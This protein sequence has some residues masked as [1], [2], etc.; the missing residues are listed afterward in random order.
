MKLGSLHQASD[1][2]GLRGINKSERLEYH[3][4]L[5][6]YV[7]MH[8]FDLSPRFPSADRIT[9]LSEALYHNIVNSPFELG[10]KKTGKLSEANIREI[11][12]NVENLSCTGELPS[13]VIEFDA[14]AIR[15][16]VQSE[17]LFY[18]ALVGRVL[19]A[20]GKMPLVKEP[21]I[22]DL[23]RRYNDDFL[24]IYDPANTA[25]A[26]LLKGVDKP[27]PLLDSTNNVATNL[28]TLLE[29]LFPPTNPPPSVERRSH[30]MLNF[31]ALPIAL[32]GEWAF[33]QTAPVCAEALQHQRLQKR[34]LSLLSEFIVV[35]RAGSWAGKKTL[36]VPDWLPTFL[37]SPEEHPLKVHCSEAV[38]IELRVGME[39][40]EL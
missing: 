28:M 33:V 34:T 31:S 32:E 26:H 27:A 11:L 8:E 13:I 2:G 30:V 18:K 3:P 39:W 16:L 24:T 9:P 38:S 20:V 1:E 10:I 6:Y 25:V 4:Q 17:A 21:A 5:L 19:E 29:V 12:E 36:V 7:G 15:A 22:Q 40:V 23:I 37:S 35:S 14:A